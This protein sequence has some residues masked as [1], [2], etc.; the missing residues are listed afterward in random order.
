M[1][2]EIKK[3]IIEETAIMKKPENSPKYK[4]KYK[5]R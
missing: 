3:V 4:I 5:I 2:E 1:I